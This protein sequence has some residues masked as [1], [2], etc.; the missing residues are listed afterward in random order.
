MSLNPTPTSARPHALPWDRIDTVLVDMDGT[1]LDLAFD[2]FFWLELVPAR[3]A[4][5]HQLPEDRAREEI[6]TAYRRLEGSLAWYCIDHWADALGIDL[7][8][9]KWEHRERIRYLPK[10][11]DFLADVRARGKRLW[12]VTN[13][14]RAV[15]AVKVGQ[16][17]LDR[18]V[19]ELICAHDFDAPKESPEFWQRFSA[20]ARFDPRRTLL[21][22]DSLS[23][24]SAARA[25][26]VAFTLAIRRPDSRLPARD[27][28][29]FPAIDGVH[30]LMGFSDEA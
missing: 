11:T 30:E 22:E 27:I 13:A 16:T 15:L 9:L 8:A 20:N 18:E 5:H 26:G 7:R 17:G 1:L 4:A 6:M 2:N 12:L 25:F 23:V 24:L 29:E 21:L 3:Y 14:H 10:A 19:D 28:D